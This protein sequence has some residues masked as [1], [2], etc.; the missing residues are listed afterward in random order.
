M[1]FIHERQ[2]FFTTLK[3]FF[4]FIKRHPVLIGNALIPALDIL[5][6]DLDLLDLGN[7]LEQKIAFD[8]LDCNIPVLFYKLLIKTVLR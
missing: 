6:D 3:I 7:F 8:P 1:Q 2:D 4:Y 5:V